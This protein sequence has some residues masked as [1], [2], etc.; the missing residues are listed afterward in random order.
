MLTLVIA[1]SFM[2]SYWFKENVKNWSL[3][4]LVGST[5]KKASRLYSNQEHLQKIEDKKKAIAC[6]HEMMHSC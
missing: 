5:F 4:H 3:L 6:G 1:K 2:H